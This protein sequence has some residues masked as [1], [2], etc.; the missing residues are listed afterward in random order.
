MFKAIHGIAPTYPSD[1]IVM[2]FYVNGYAIRG[3]DMEIYL[4]RLRKE[5]FGNS[6][7]KCIDVIYCIL[8]GIY[9]WILF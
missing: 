6:L 7:M 8:I 9:Y 3:S 1:R 4:P 2:E 5:A